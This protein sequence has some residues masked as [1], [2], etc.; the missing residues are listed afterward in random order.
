MLSGVAPDD[1]VVKLS[2]RF[3]IGELTRM[4]NL[5]Q[6]T[7]SGFSKSASRRMDAE[8]CIVNLCQP[9]LSDD[10]ESMLARVTR[11]EDQMKAGLVAAPAQ[12][13]PVQ[14][15]AET[16]VPFDTATM[17]S[18]VPTE[19]PKIDEAPIGFWSDMTAA[20][21]SENKSPAAGFFT[22][23]ED[24]HVKGVLQG[25]TLYLVCANQFTMDIINKQ[26]I[27]ALVQL[28]ASAKLGRQIRVAIT[29]KT[30]SAKVGQQME[31]LLAFGRDHADLVNIK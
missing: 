3:S 18:R 17:I 25:D 24:A 20:I 9:E 16:P 26:D 7:V 27:L 30:M 1:E 14:G 2:E 19:P 5:I 22:T 31:Q 10:L 29:D 6:K 13:T 11:L 4:M 28:K 8:L 23:G 21:R 12:A 15:A